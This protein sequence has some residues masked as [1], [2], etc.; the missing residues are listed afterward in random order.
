MAPKAWY[1]LTHESRSKMDADTTSAWGFDKT[2]RTAAL[3]RH[4]HPILQTF[5]GHPYAVYMRL[6]SFA[7]SHRIFGTPHRYIGGRRCPLRRSSTRRS[8]CSSGEDV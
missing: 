3:L 2:M 7:H 6:P 1:V 8:P 4:V 5:F